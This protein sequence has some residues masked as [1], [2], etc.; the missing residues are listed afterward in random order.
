M[1]K[2][3]QIIKRNFGELLVFSLLFLGIALS[4]F[5]DFL[6]FH[7]FAEI[8]SVII[9]GGIFIIGWNT[10]KYSKSSFFLILGISSAFIGFFDLLHTL[11]Y[12]GMG[13]F[14]GFNANLPTQLWI[15]ARYLQCIS[16]L[17]AIVMLNKDAK[18]K[19]W[20]ITYSV[21]SSI[22]IIFIFTNLFPQC[23][24]QG[25]G[26]TLFKIISEYVIIGILVIS[27]IFLYK[28]RNQFDRNVFILLIL[29]NFIMIL[30]E[31][32]FTLYVD[33][34]GIFNYVGHLL[35]IFEFYLIY[36]GIIQIGLRFPFRSLLRKI[37]Q[38][39]EYLRES[40]QRTNFYKDLFA[41]DI[42]NIVQNLKLSL[43]IFEDKLSGTELIKK[44]KTIQKLLGN[45]QS[46]IN[47]GINLIY[48][49]RK[50]SE[51]DSRAIL[52]SDIQIEEFL[53]NS[54]DFIKKSY[55][56]KNI[57]IKAEVTTKTLIV[58][59]NDLLQEVFENILTNAILHNNNEQ[60]NIIVE[61]KDSPNNPNIYLRIEFKDN[62]LGVPD[63]NKKKIFKEGYKEAKSSTGMG[64]G[65]SLV[66][67]ILNLFKGTIWVEDRIQ[68]DYSKGS[69]F[70][71]E[72]P[73]SH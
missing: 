30:S 8:F 12:E 47:R 20:F 28:K 73:K 65:L 36:K 57:N 7:S 45:A 55:E 39:E 29:S 42:S 64:L 27:I 52:L 48:N 11:S 10:H 9:M 34:Y 1:E 31:F 51:I 24:I 13:V 15:V 69:N 18:R 16:L 66:V 41:H 71:I 22:L 53:R 2:E 60:I 3:N 43:G 46:Q 68:G 37:K 23:Y 72:L 59:A 4:R 70:I 67:K 50:L 25:H 35:K 19:L 49:V 63:K 58:K 62:G 40:Y 5:Y 33:V 44:D 32:S 26:L 17:L 61:I 14:K 56:N 54:I 38:S 6:I 21:I